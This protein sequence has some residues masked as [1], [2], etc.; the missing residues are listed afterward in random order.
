MGNGERAHEES[1]ETLRL[2][3]QILQSGIQESVAIQS[4]NSILSLRTND[5]IFST[6]DLAVIDLHKATS[7][8]IKVGST[9]SFI[10][11]GGQISLWS[12]ETCQ[13][14]LSRKSTSI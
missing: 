4:I 2:L 11:R 13:W 14:E 8:F 9:P 1:M 7:K 10:K 5:E 12:Q 3:K 6:L